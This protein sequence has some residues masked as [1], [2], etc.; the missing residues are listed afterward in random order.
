MNGMYYKNPRDDRIHYIQLAWKFSR[1]QSRSTMTSGDR[2]ALDFMP[3]SGCAKGLVGENVVV[4]EEWW[5]TGIETVGDEAADGNKS[6]L[7]TSGP[8]L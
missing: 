1:I 2:R 4:V 3:K 5:E 8:M 7:P 6:S